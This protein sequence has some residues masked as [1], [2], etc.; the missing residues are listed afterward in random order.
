MSKNNVIAFVFFVALVVGLYGYFSGFKMSKTP[1][2]TATTTSDKVNGNPTNISERG[3]IVFEIING[4]LS[5]P[6][7]LYTKAGFTTQE[8]S[9]LTFD[10]LS[11][12]VVGNLGT[13]C[14]SISTAFE[15]YFS[16]RSVLVEG[17][18]SRE[19]I[20]VR[21]L[22]VMEE[23]QDGIVSA[24]GNIFVSWE[25]AVRFINSCSVKLAGQTHA[26]DVY[27]KMKDGTNVRTVEP[28]IDEVFRVVHNAPKTCGNIGLAT[29]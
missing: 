3:R 20:L 18:E 21:K 6:F 12:C 27:L 17:I 29:E 28:V 22:R 16:G 24:P 15:S 1:A 10:A 4:Q 14:L 5:A 19:E 25:Q 7:F 8:S 23:G 26:L 13:P 9:T 2:D 11:S